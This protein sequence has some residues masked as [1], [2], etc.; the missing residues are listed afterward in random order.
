M[1]FSDKLQSIY[2]ENKHNNRVLFEKLRDAIVE[3]LESEADRGSNYSLKAHIVRMNNA[4]KLF[5]KDKPRFN[6][7]GFEKMVKDASS[8]VAKIAFGKYN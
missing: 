1:L 6:E 3:E 8:D 2:E 4:W 7:R 5:C